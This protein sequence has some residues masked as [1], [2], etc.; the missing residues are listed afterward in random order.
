MEANPVD[1]V[2]VLAAAVGPSPRAPGVQRLCLRKGCGALFAPEV[3]NQRYC[4]DST[5]LKEVRRWQARKRKQRARKNPKVREKHA[6]AERVRRRG[7][8]RSNGQRGPPRAGAWSR[9]DVRSEKICDRPGCWNEPR[10][11]KH[12]SASYCGRECR[13]AMQRVLDRERKCRARH[14]KRR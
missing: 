12:S 2:S 14:R 11:G 13:K 3:W 4:Q 5:C 8:S 6:E 7:K 10:T 1:R 9:N